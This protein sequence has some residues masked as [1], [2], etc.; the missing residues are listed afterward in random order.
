MLLLLPGLV[1]I[2]IGQK[3]VDPV[4]GD[5]SPIIGVRINPETQTVVPVTLSSGAHKKRKPPLGAV[6]MLEDEIV[7]RRS[8][9]RRQRQREAELTLQ[10][11]ELAQKIL[12]E[13]ESIKSKKLKETLEALA[14]KAHGLDEAAKREVQ[15]RSEAEQEF[16]A[17]LPPDVCA[18]LTEGDEAERKA[19]ETHYKSH[20]KLSETIQKLFTK[21][22]NEE[23]R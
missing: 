15:R 17:V 6:T 8:F 13:I 5:L 12:Y 18:I 21:L 16:S 4:T 7:A 11:F 9:W 23:D 22:Q 10:E 2:M 19:E 3:A 1:P 20:G 14:Q